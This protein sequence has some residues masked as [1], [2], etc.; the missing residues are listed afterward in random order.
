MPNPAIYFLGSSIVQKPAPASIPST[1]APVFAGITNAAPNTD[2][3]ISASWSAGTAINPP[4]SYKVYIARGSVSAATLFNSL[5]LAKIVPANTLTARLF[6]LA[7]Q[8]YLVRDQEY[9]LGVRAVDAYGNVETNTA[10]LTATSVGI[11]AEPLYEPKAKFS[12]DENNQ[13]N[14]TLWVTQNLQFYN[15][16]LG[17]ASY[18]IYD[19]DGNSVGVAESGLTADVNGYYQITPVSASFYN[20][21]EHYLVKIII[22]ANGQNRTGSVPLQIN[23]EHFFEPKGNFSIND[24]KQIQGTLWLLENGEQKSTNLGNASYTVYDSDN[25]A[26]VA[27]ESGLTAD[28]NGL[29]KTSLINFPLYDEKKHYTVKLNIVADNETRTVFIPLRVNKEPVYEIRGAFT[30]D[31]ANYLLGTIWVTQDL[32]NYNTNLGTASYVIKNSSGVPIG[33]SESNIAPDGSGA[34]RITPVL[35]TL[36]TSFALYT[37]EITVTVN[38]DQKTGRIALVTGE[39]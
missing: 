18:V 10:I 35:A 11:D 12:I 31:A 33:I 30:V 20:E 1:V 34:Y 6:L 14:G 39:F 3:S 15:V 22:N 28:I 17:N 16:S 23:P 25:N 7:D 29:Y 38:G 27:T 4:I 5:N 8:T 9:T 2:G 26:T 32:E 36:I 37:V 13:L 19:K 24:L 21:I